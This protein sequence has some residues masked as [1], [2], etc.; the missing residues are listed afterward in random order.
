MKHI[1][2]FIL[3][4]SFFNSGAQFNPLQPPNTFSTS[5]NPYYWKN[6]ASLVKNGYWQQDVHY[7]IDANIDEETDIITA[8]EKLIYSNNSPHDLSFVYFHLYQNAFQPDSYLDELE[9]VNKVDT[10]YGKYESKKLGTTV[11]SMK[12]EGIDCKTELDNTILKVYLPK[13]L[14]SGESITFDID[15]NTY[16]D[17]GGN[18]QRR[19]KEFINFEKKHYD[20]VHWYPR[21]CVYDKKF[22]WTTDQ[23]LGKE[24]YGDFGTFDVNLTFNKSFVVEATGNL[25]NS[26]EVLPDTLRKRLDISNFAKKPWNSNPSIIIPYIKGENKTWKYHAENVHDFAFT[27]DPNYRIGETS[28]QT[29]GYFPHEVKVV[30]LVLE[31]HASRWQNAADYTKKVIEVYNKDFGNYAYNKMV[32]ADAEDGME[33]PMLTLDGGFE[34]NYRGLLAH[35]VGHNWFFGMVGNNETYRACLDEGFTQFLTAWSLR[36]ID[37]ENLVEKPEKHWYRKKFKKPLNVV[38]TRVYNQYL[39]DALAG[40][41]TTLNTHSDNFNGALGHEG[42]YRQVYY[43]T[44]TML[45]NLQYVLGDSLFLA[46]MQNYFEEWKIAH[47]YIEDF[48]NSIINFTHVDLNWFFDEWLETNKTVDY[49]IESVK[50]INKKNDYEIT[51]EREGRMQMPIDISIT[52]KKDS[53]F[54]FHI[55]ND[56]FVKNTKATVLK[57]WFGWDNLNQQ[58]KFIANI[59]E[60]IKQVQIDPSGRLA[61]KDRTNNYLNNKKVWSFDH[62]LYT[63][64]DWEHYNIYW[65]PDVWYNKIDGVKI[66]VNLNGN[67]V[68][69]VNKFSFSAWYNTLF[70]RDNSGFTPTGTKY[71]TNDYYFNNDIINDKTLDFIFKRFNYNFNYETPISHLLQASDLN[72][73]MRYLDGL[74]LYK[75][76]IQTKFRNGKTSIKIYQ[77]SFV[78]LMGSNLG[79]NEY[80]MNPKQWNVGGWNSSINLELFH[81]YNYTNGVGNITAK[82]R[83][84]S[85]GSASRYSYINLE[86]INKNHL[87]KFDI[88]TRFFIQYG[89]VNQPFESSLNAAGAN[90]EEMLENKYVRSSSFMPQS[91]NT[92]GATTN[93][94][95][96][97]GGLNLRGYNG[98]LLPMTDSNGN[99]IF[100]NNSKSGAAINTEI[101]FDRFFNFRVKRFSN[102]L[103]I[104]TYAFADAGFLAFG[105][106]SQNISP[107]RVDAG[108]GTSFTI[109]K[110]WVLEKTSPLTIR[111]DCPFFLNTPPFDEGKYFKFRWLLSVERA[112]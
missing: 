108:L 96:F 94:F 11:N 46:A 69:R 12:I 23:H 103:K 22:G 4:I 59:P 63:P 40:S 42:G 8:K 85:L 48:R 106:F 17:Y 51:L 71:R 64:N 62:R 111:F 39:Q 56:W 34:P 88:N 90:S 35:E 27:A 5:D 30:S 70:L 36:K 54:N 52:N 68:E 97:G 65:R 74:Q 78:R 110:W 15:F 99:Q 67:Y 79:A 80:L 57:K 87:G 3:L 1:L 100:L 81:K 25:L 6:R 109:K 86:S 55:P 41:E 60:G 66:G 16:F 13:V 2:F 89:D 38:Q 77:K 84:S 28:L 53:V 7:T 44:A 14:K 9:K 112:F 33:Y 72:I 50:R 92:L 19:M 20:G 45:Y 82:F 102:W 95:Q 104:N 105:N 43:K 10:K 83:T 76:G 21:I 93:H 37:G 32:V 26:N 31:Q 58:Y 101:G 91:W 73:D 107:V 29:N 24:F 61:D 49:E 18:T 75:L 98:Y 47:P